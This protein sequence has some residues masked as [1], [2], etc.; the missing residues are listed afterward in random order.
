M[1]ISHRS[2]M[3]PRR[4]RRGTLPILFASLCSTAAVAIAGE[5]T[6]VSIGDAG[7][8][9]PLDSSA[10][11]SRGMNG[12]GTAV[13]F[14]SFSAGLVD[15]DT[16]GVRDVF[17]RDLTSGRTTRV[18]V[19]SDGGEGDGNS[20]NGALS[21]NGRFVAFASRATNLVAGDG[22]EAQDVF[23]HDRQSGVTSR[24][25]VNSAGIEGN[26]ASG[27]SAFLAVSGDGGS[28]VF[29]SSATNLVAAD[30]NGEEDIFHHDMRTHETVRVSIAGDGSES[31]GFSGYPSPCANG[32][33]VAFAS[34]AT[35]LVPGDTNDAPDVFV[36]DLRRGTTKRVSVAGDGT[37][38]DGSSGV[39]SISL[40]GRVVAFVSLAANLVP[41]DTNDAADVF[42]RDLKAGTTTRV[43]VASDGTEANA[44]SPTVA[45][46]GSGRFVLFTSEADNLVPADTNHADDVFLHD[47]HTGRT[48]RVNVD[49]AGVQSSGILGFDL[50]LSV[51][52]R[53]ILFSSDAGTLVPGDTNGVADV[54]LHDTK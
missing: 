22:N 28:V 11:Y 42:V 10:H 20:N 24:V 16:N 15:G 13:S 18:S 37:E 12:A 49:G 47:R 7:Q 30:T 40:N 27:S 32:K 25:S 21:S 53:R 26:S 52:G 3:P 8:E 54:F 4:A 46:S 2:P 34:L 14:S 6:R 45:L 19:A 41:G 50:A 38:G 33:V 5:T 29:S 36:R 51:N 44:G 35:N 9:A 17:V 39:P 48:T 23:L 1:P 31:D 43:S